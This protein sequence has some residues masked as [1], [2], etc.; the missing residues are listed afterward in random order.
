MDLILDLFVDS[1]VSRTLLNSPD[2]DPDINYYNER[3]IDCSYVTCEDLKPHVL[4]N[5][6]LLSLLHINCRSISFKL[7]EVERLLIC[8]NIDVLAV[9]ETWLNNDTALSV[10][11][12]GYDFIFNNRPGGGSGGVGFY[13]KCNINYAR[14]SPL[15][16]EINHDTY[17]S[18]SSSSP[19][20]WILLYCRG[21]LSTSWTISD[22]V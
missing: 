13:V 17:E 2:L 3:P 15:P 14:Y 21:H 8:L 10:N 9:T 11:I 16:T 5:N 22:T 4:R 19:N 18:L 1:D 6:N 20:E 7:G 12:P